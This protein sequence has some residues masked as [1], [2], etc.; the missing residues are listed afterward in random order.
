MWNS[1]IGKKSQ[2]GLLILI[3]LVTVFIVIWMINMFTSTAQQKRII[4]TL[5]LSKLSKYLDFYKGF[6]RQALLLA[7]HRATQEVASQGGEANEGGISRYWICNS[8]ISP[9]IE[10]VR[11]FLSERT[12][13]FLN[14]YIMNLK[15]DELV[16]LNITNFTCVD[17]DVNENSVMSG[18]NDERFNV[19]GYGSEIN[20]SYKADSVYSENNIYEEIAQD[21]FWYMYRNFKVWSQTTSF[22]GCICG[23]LGAGCCCPRGDC[24]EDVC[25]AFKACVDGCFKKAKNELESKFDDYV[26]CGYTFDCC[27]IETIE[28]GD[29]QSPCEAWKDAP[30][31]NICAKEDPDILCS[32]NL[33]LSGENSN[34]NYYTIKLQEDEEEEF[35][36]YGG[37]YFWD[38]VRAA[39]E[40]EFHCKDKKYFLSTENYRYLDFDTRVMMNIKGRQC[41]TTADCEEK[42]TDEG[43]VCRCD[44]NPPCGK[45]CYQTCS[46]EEQET[47]GVELPP[48]EEWSDESCGDCDPITCKQICSKYCI[49]GKHFV[50]HNNVIYPCDPTCAVGPG[51]PYPPG[52]HPTQT[53]VPPT[54]PPGPPLE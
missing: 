7:T 14:R 16:N 5:K 17:Y 8:D 34:K 19:G 29:V 6:S 10:S 45:W 31:C 13:K 47:A 1:K 51:P 36:C 52:P 22:P 49:D 32:K 42:E 18:K 3:G 54:V 12:E 26:K 30:K 38:E 43:K 53:T 24:L 25:P 40:G 41:E 4:E 28:C 20:I 37:C 48:C 15:S 35:Q 9:E 44:R 50:H 46:D 27:Y 11:F 21:R 39:I 2:S 33:E 23:C